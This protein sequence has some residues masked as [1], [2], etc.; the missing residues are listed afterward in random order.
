MYKEK[1]PVSYPLSLEKTPETEAACEEDFFHWVRRIDALNPRHPRTGHAV[2]PRDEKIRFRQIPHLHFAPSSIGRTEHRH[3]DNTNQSVEE[4]MVYFMGLLGVNG[5]LPAI[6]SDVILAKAKGVPHPD[7][8]DLHSGESAFRSDAGPAAF[9]DLFNHRFISLFYRAAV[10]SNKA[11]DFDRPIESRFH[12]FIGSF[13]GLG[14]ATTQNRMHIPDTAALYFAG[15]YACHTKHAE[16]L[17]QMIADYTGAHVAIDEN[18]GHWVPVPSENQ[19]LLG[20]NR[21]AG[22]LGRSAMLGSRY[23]DR[24]MKFCL[25]IG[26]LTLAQFQ[27]YPPDSDLVDAIRSIMLL[28]CGREFHCELNPV[29][30]KAEVPMCVLGRDSRLGFTSWLTSKPAACDASDYKISIIK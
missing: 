27:D 10:S 24:T 15:H 20:V 13:I 23:W 5:P 22:D 2:V 8:E 4:I 16:G 6:I 25:K 14:N 12:T 19:T 18:V 26:P 11:V 17:C 7:M 30:Q 9:I 1:Y 28:Y 21:S 29:L 3:D